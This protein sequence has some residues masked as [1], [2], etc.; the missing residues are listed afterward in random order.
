MIFTLDKDI[1]ITPNLITGLLQKHTANE[2]FGKQ[3]ELIDAYLGKYPILQTEKETYKPNN[4]VVNN[5]AKYIVDTFCG[6][7][8]GKPLSVT[9]Q[10]EMVLE[11][12]KR[13]NN[14]NTTDFLNFELIKNAA[15]Y[16]NCYELIYQ[17]EEGVT[18]STIINPL[19]GFLVFDDTVKKKPLFGVCYRVDDDN[20]LTGEIYS[21]E[22]MYSFVG[23]NLEVATFTSKEPNKYCD[24]QMIEYRF[25]AERQGIFE[26]QLTL[27][28]AYNKAL[29]EKANDVDYFGDS[30][31]VITN[32]EP[33]DRMQDETEEQ[34][35]E[36]MMDNIRDN[37]IIIFPPSGNQGE[38]EVEVKFLSKP[39]VDATQENL[40]NRI[41]ENIFHLS[42]VANISDESFGTASGVALQYKLLNM[43]NLAQSVEN[44]LTESL[45]RRYKLVF[46]FAKNL[47]QSLSNEWQTLEFK[48][49]EN[50]PVNP[51]EVANTLNA[52][53]AE[54][55]EE[56]ALKMAQ[57][58]NPE[59]E[60]ERLEE[61]RKKSGGELFDI[62]KGE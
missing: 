59:Q 49:Y 35:L 19:E 9:S 51:L 18:C 43:R 52:L 36:R 48:F 25:N 37:R 4:K 10:N 53:G 45:R 14:T 2:R 46:S 22:Y 60:M 6:F 3:Q 54:V 62:E 42:M 24:V 41:E 23:E 27:I 34:A 16:G 32:A 7:F 30:Y 11:A 39:E 38:K 57:V 12:V 17:D 50:L 26:N 8:D 61:E 29:S 15:I 1:E 28:N 40:L 47:P 33:G 56:T 55:S 44:N 5:Y 20:I 31:L 21:K 58:D 13:F